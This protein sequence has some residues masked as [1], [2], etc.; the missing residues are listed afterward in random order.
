MIRTHQLPLVIEEPLRV[1]G[2]GLLPEVGVVTDEGHVT[3][4]L[5]HPQRKACVNL[6]FGQDVVEEVQSALFDLVAERRGEYHCPRLR[7][8]ASEEEPDTHTHT[9]T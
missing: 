2:P 5:Q 3:P 8:G 9:H 6:F 1:E 7:H 4:N